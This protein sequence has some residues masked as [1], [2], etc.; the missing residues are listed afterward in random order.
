MEAVD[1]DHCEA[2]EI[3]ETEVFDEN[4]MFFT[5]EVC[6]CP[7]CGEDFLFPLAA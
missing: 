6:L 1:C 3:G 2:V 5:K 4:D 7:E